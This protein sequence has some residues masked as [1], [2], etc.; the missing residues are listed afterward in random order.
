[1]KTVRDRY[2]VD[3]VMQ[4]AEIAERNSKSNYKKKPFTFPDGSTRMVQGYEV[5]ALRDLVEE[6]PDLT[7]ADF[8]TDRTCVPTLWYTGPDS[9]RHRHFVD[10]HIPQLNRCIE[11][12]SPY[13]LRQGRLT[14][15]LKK[16]SGLEMGF[17]YRIWMYDRV[18]YNTYERIQEL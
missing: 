10:I 12:K 7:S 5:H 16:Q 11:V 3:N 6:Y 18:R 9:K 15:P 13:T 2:G 8:I 14:L 17:D 1:M 4:N